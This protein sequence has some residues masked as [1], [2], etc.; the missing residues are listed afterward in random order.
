[1]DKQLKIASELIEKL[2]AEKKRLQEKLQYI[3]MQLRPDLWDDLTT[4]AKK[5]YPEGLV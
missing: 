1:M 2:L 4:I 3:R 5:K